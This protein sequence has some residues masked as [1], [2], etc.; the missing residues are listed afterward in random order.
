MGEI[1]FFVVAIGPLLLLLA[2]I[3]ATRRNRNARKAQ[4]ARSE[5][6][7]RQLREDLRRDP[8]YRED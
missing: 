6:G 2:M 7:A 4:I 1:W 5:E 3:W 8:Q